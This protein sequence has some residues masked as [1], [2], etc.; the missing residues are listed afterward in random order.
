MLRAAQT[1]FSKSKQHKATGNKIIAE[2]L[3][4]IVSDG[5]GIFAGGSLVGLG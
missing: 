4:L 2:Q 5:R 3:L 1:I